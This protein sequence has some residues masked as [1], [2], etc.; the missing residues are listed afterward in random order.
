MPCHCER[1]MMGLGLGTA[2]IQ[3][4]LAC[5]KLSFDVRPSWQSQPCV[6]GFAACKC[7]WCVFDQL[8]TV[9]LA[10]SS[11]TVILGV[12]I[13]VLCAAVLSCHMHIQGRDTTSCLPFVSLPVACIT[14][15]Y[16]HPDSMRRVSGE[17]RR[18]LQGRGISNGSW[19][20]GCAGQ[21]CTYSF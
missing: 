8:S 9:V 7:I 11:S 13:R 19:I 18:G 15:L 16:P 1:C 17:E 4:V 14:S 6:W 3:Q 20:S 21:G 12:S 5:L 10:C 2:G